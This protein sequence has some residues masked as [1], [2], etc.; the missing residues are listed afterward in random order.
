MPIINQETSSSFQYVLTSELSFP[1]TQSII[2]SSTSYSDLFISNNIL[3]SSILTISLSELN[4]FSL[5]SIVSSIPNFNSNLETSYSEHNH[6]YSSNINPFS[7]NSTSLFV[8]IHEEKINATKENIT[9]ILQSIIE[10]IEIGQVYKKIGNNLTILIFPTNSKFFDNTSHV[11]FIECEKQLR[12]Y[13]KIQ[14]SSIMTFLQIELENDNSKSLINQIEYQALDA[15]KTMLDL[16]IC[17]NTNIQVFYSIKNNSQVDFKSAENFKQSGIDIFNINDSFFNDICKPYSESNNDL[18]LEDRIKYKYQNYSLCEIGCSYDKMDFEHMTILCNC[19]VKNNI[20]IV[21]SPINFQ[22]AEGSSTNFDVVKCSNLVFSF[23]GKFDNIGFWILGILVLFQAP[24]LIYYFNKGIKP[25]REYILKEMKKYGYIKDDNDIKNTNNKNSKKKKKQMNISTIKNKKILNS[26]PHK[27]NNKR[28]HNKQDNKFTIK[29]FKLIN[30][31]SSINIIKSSNR[32]IMPDI[33]DN[34]KRKVILNNNENKIA[35]KKNFTRKFYLNKTKI[36]KKSNI[37]KNSNKIKNITHLPT[38]DISKNKDEENKIQD[39]N[40]KNKNLKVYTLINMDL[41][42]SRNKKY[43]PPDSHIILNNYTFKEAVKYDRRQ[44]CVIFYIYA[45]SK[46]IFF[47]TFLFRSPL[48]LFPLRLCL[49]I[50]IISSDLALNALFYFNENISKKYRHA[51]NLFLFAFSDN[52]TVIIL[53]TVVGFILLTL[54]AKLSNSTNAI[55]EVFRK[56]EEKLKK[57]KKYK[58][59][60]KRK[61]EIL[62]E[63]EEILKK[64][65]IKIVILIIV[66][67]ILMLFFWYFVIAFC[68][69]YKATQLSWLWDS[70]LSILSRAIIELLISFGLAKLYRIAVESESHCL[71]KLTMFLYNLS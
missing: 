9:E 28:K 13:Y 53:S 7:I 11:N 1:S 57:D 35:K 23:E 63:I 48:E 59:T 54:L 34:K 15:N 19:K 69:V 70:F 43:I 67:L 60:E 12:N 32:D 36:N 66:E 71:Y 40:K 52:I 51:K 58:V 55:R 64:Y 68:H 3:L 47:H 44:T 5:D 17:E 27:T 49:F 10:E 21:I 8:K 38:Q 39:E 25:V 45:L 24:L 65:K 37:S 16:S 61:T 20:S 62:M 4:N 29:N 14:N 56:E 31:S 18:I 30:N 6:I 26:P 41:N 46:Q 42:L 50:F 33:N 2:S 22:Q